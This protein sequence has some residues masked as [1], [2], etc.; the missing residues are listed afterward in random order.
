MSDASK[1]PVETLL[2]HLERLGKPDVRSWDDLLD[3]N[4]LL[5]QNLLASGDESLSK[6]AIPMLIGYLRKDGRPTLA[7]LAD[8]LDQEAKNTGW[9]LTLGRRGQGNHPAS[10][11]RMIEDLG[12]KFEVGEAEKQ[13]KSEGS[14]ARGRRKKAI[15]DVAKAR[16][17]K[18]KRV[19]DALTRA[20]LPSK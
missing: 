12:I 17:W 14:P 2:A 5:I 9:K 3:Q 20:N 10:D 18:D 6:M 15:G 16:G 11:R 19:R 8:W 13:L 1:D 7:M 4:P